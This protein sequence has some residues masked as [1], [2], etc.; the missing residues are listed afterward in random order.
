MKKEWEIDKMLRCPQNET[1]GSLHIHR[2]AFCDH[3]TY[4]KY[5]EDD[6]QQRYLEDNSHIGH[7]Y[8]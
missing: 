3:H 8:H 6:R 5:Y 4:Y 1:R 2:E 7:K